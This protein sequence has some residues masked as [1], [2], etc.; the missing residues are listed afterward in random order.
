[1]TER[2][3]AIRGRG[4]PSQRPGGD[5][6]TT[7]YEMYGGTERH[8]SFKRA[9]RGARGV[10]VRR[11][12]VNFDH[13]RRPQHTFLAVLVVIEVEHVHDSTTYTVSPTFTF[14]TG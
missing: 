12:L 9:E 6:G 7:G 1:M 8:V 10:G 4:L 3:E 2:F 13:E 11:G 5:H 14:G